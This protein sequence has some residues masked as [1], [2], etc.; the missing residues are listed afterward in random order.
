MVVVI[1][2]LIFG[3]VVAIAAAL[4]I[5][6]AG[7]MGEAPPPA[8]FDPD[9]AQ[10]WVV[11]QLPEIA[12]ATLS[13]ADVRRILDFQMEFFARLGITLGAAAATTAEAALVGGDDEITYIEKRSAAT[14]EAY[15][16]EQIAAVI[17]TQIAY[18][19]AIGAIGPIA[20]SGEYPPLS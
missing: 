9:D 11:E 10:T 2:F 6:E 17:E 8:I 1:G 12:A 19:L 20:D 18:L 15:L 5:R 3:L 7:R 13:V 14:G 16:P 4:V